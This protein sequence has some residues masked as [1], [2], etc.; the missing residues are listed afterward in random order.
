MRCPF[1]EV[2]FRFFMK[3]STGLAASLTELIQLRRQGMQL[4]LRPS[5]KAQSVLSGNHVSRF[6]GRGMDF[7]ESRRY[8]NGDDVRRIDWRV[9]ARTGQ[10]HTK[11]YVEEKERP[12]F[13]LVDFSLSMFFGSRKCLKTVTAAKEHT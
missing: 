9:T 8:Q 13:I 6:R 4:E 11:I 12:V 5:T 3:L 10:T 2:G 1:P 7:A